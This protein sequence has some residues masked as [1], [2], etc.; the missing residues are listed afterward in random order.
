MDWCLS[1]EDRLKKIPANH[2]KS[3]EHIEKAKHDLLATDYNLK[4]GFND[5][6]VSQ[7][8]YSTELSLHFFRAWLP[9]PCIGNM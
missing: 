7:A 8:L 3:K 9:A 4:G 2:L 6:A 5:W 1:K